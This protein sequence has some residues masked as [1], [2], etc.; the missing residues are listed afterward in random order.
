MSQITL[1]LDEETQELVE[2]S[3]KAQGVSKSRWVADII[4]KHAGEAWPQ[5]C[6]ALAGSFPDFP[7]REL[8][9]EPSAEDAAR[10]G[11]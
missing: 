9:A 2:R 11:W 7:L 1:Y 5:D 6:L 10:L 8:P 4:R 3:A